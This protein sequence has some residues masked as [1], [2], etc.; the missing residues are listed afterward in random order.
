METFA[1]ECKGSDLQKSRAKRKS[2][3]EFHYSSNQD[4]KGLAQGL[5]DNLEND[6]SFTSIENTSNLNEKDMK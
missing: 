1:F 4:L 3:S 2:E 6:F 5:D